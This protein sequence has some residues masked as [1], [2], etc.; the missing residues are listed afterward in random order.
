MEENKH[1]SPEK[2][3]E[4][5]E[6]A[7]EKMEPKSEEYEDE[8][9]DKITILITTISHGEKIILRSKIATLEA[10]ED[11]EIELKSQPWYTFVEKTYIYG[12]APFGNVCLMSNNPANTWSRASTKRELEQT[13][14]TIPIDTTS[15][16]SFAKTAKK[17]NASFITTSVLE[18]ETSIP[19]KRGVIMANL[20]KEEKDELP[21][22]YVPTRGIMN[23]MNMRIEMVP[24]MYVLS[25]KNTDRQ[26]EALK[27]NPST[28]I[29]WNDKYSGI[30]V[31]ILSDNKGNTF[32]FPS[33]FNLADGKHIIEIF[34]RLEQPIPEL[35]TNID[36]KE[37]YTVIN[38]YLTDWNEFVDPKHQDTSYRRDAALGV[39]WAVNVYYVKDKETG[40]LKTVSYFIL[41]KLNTMNV[42][43]LA[44]LVFDFLVSKKNNPN[45]P[46]TKTKDELNLWIEELKGK[47]SKIINIST[48]CEGVNPEKMD[49]GTIQDV[50]AHINDSS[51][52]RTVTQN[53]TDD[54]GPD[55]I[56]FDDLDEYISQ[57]EVNAATEAKGR[58]KIAY[59]YSPIKLTS[60]ILTKK[61]AKKLKGINRNINKTRRN[62]KRG[63]KK[64][65]KRWSNKHN[66]KKH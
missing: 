36:G 16:K 2:I 53:Y 23:P 24:S 61:Q 63:T 20:F 47:N 9:E 62:K 59:S 38:S 56:H 11:Y 43:V 27:E 58:A 14:S 60:N 65:Y 52:H 7:I 22:E 46:Y 49:E 48:A 66:K 55:L 64:K 57:L 39:T 8:D 44:N 37:L 1:A 28:F 5:L 25:G 34:T 51:L 40:K 30:F 4:K 54:D 42:Y 45:N 18:P 15:R 29:A 33:L 32:K 31:S 50:A 21:V 10:F 19:K 3:L 6:T 17:I 12:Y 35:N 13:F 26:E 41:T